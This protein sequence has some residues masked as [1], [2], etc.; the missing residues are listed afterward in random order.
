[1]ALPKYQKQYQDMVET[2]KDLFASLKKAD[3]KS[4]EFKDIQLK[5]LRIVRRNEDALC[6]K[7]ESTKFM[8]FSLGLADKFL[9]VVRS[10][11]PEIDFA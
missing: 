11:Y 2:H 10:E 8:S 3:R 4:E 1:M 6:K 5:V 9:E 7:T